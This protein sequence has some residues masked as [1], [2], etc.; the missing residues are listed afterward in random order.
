MIIAI[1]RFTMINFHD[2]FLK[3]N[4]GVQVR[5]YIFNALIISL[6]FS[7]QFTVKI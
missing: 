6:I 1:N 5:H 7:Q 3:K 2:T 4:L